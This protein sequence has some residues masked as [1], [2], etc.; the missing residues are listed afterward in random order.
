MG[1]GLPDNEYREY[2]A[3]DYRLHLCWKTS[4]PAPT[5]VAPLLPN[6]TA[7]SADVADPNPS[8]CSECPWCWAGVDM[9]DGLP[10]NEYR[11]YFAPDYKLHLHPDPQVPDQNER[12]YL[13]DVVREV[14]S[15]LQG[16]AFQGLAGLPPLHAGLCMWGGWKL[17][18]F[19]RHP[20]A[21]SLHVQT[22]AQWTIKDDV[23]REV[24]S[25]LQGYTFLG[26]WGWQFLHFGRK[27]EGPV[28]VAGVC[29]LGPGRL[30]INACEE[31][32]GVGKTL[33]SQTA[34]KCHV[35]HVEGGAGKRMEKYYPSCRGK[36]FRAPGACN[37]HAGLCMWG[38]GGWGYHLH[39]RH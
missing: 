19:H 11:E 27:M 2:F 36:P 30:A 3:P 22:Q 28:L 15:Q 35:L 21:L 24:L 18:C 10:D 39:R 33:Q 6:S 12:R 20:C 14:L 17:C 13:D 29:L 23:V 5:H 25:Q 37:L 8:A 16:Y 9:E 26:P 7:A 38:V 34:L 4:A 32:G 31:G 1:D